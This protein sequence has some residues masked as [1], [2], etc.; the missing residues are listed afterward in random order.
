MNSSGLFG[1]SRS[2]TDLQFQNTMARISTKVPSA[3]VSGSMNEHLHRHPASADKR[4]LK[5]DGEGSRASKR[6]KVPARTDYSRWRLL[7]EKGRLTWHFLEDDE[8]IKAW[9]QS[10]ADRYFLGLSLVE[11]SIHIDY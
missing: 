9:P 1:I 4:P 3:S 5:S 6:T 8:K 10:L 11:S 7:D 2:V